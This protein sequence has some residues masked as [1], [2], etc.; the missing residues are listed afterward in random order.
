MHFIKTFSHFFLSVTILEGLRFNLR[1]GEAFNISYLAHTA[2]LQIGCRL[3]N[4]SRVP[5]SENEGCTAHT[6]AVWIA[7]LQLLRTD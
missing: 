6:W 5:L 4:K 3:H 7:Y 2:E 1:D